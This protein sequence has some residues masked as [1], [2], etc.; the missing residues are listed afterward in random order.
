MT[1]SDRVRVCKTDSDRRMEWIQWNRIANSR[2]ATLVVAWYLN[3]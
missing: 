1:D 2:K 3:S